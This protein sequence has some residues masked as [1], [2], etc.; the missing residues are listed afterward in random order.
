MPELFSVI[1]FMATKVFERKVCAQPPNIL[2]HLL[3]FN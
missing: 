3:F 2:M 1:F